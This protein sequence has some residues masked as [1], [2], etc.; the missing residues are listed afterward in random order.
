VEETLLFCNLSALVCGFV[1]L[2]MFARQKLEGL[3]TYNVTFNEN[4]I[5]ASGSSS[6][7]SGFCFVWRTRKIKGFEPGHYYF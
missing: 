3:K 4:K 5:R 6:G 2:M 1:V 7:V